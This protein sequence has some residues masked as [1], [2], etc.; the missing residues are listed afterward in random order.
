[1]EMIRKW[2][3]QYSYQK[4]WTLKTIK[5][6]KGHHIRIKGSVCEEDNTVIILYA[7]NMGAPKY[8]KQILTYRK[9]EISG[10]TL[11]LTHN[12]YQWTHLPQRE[13]TGQQRF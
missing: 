1:M 6:D 11:I 9:G 12:S 8:I 10:T 2:E 4:K 13:S 5:K 3:F 7:C